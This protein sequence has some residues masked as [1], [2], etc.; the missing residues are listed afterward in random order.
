MCALGFVLMLTT[1]F[2]SALSGF[3]RIRLVDNILYFYAQCR[4][5]VMT[6]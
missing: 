6:F 1:L 5:N 3:E 2:S 4:G